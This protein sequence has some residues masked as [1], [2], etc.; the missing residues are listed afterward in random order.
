MDIRLRSFSS[1]RRGASRWLRA[2]AIAAGASAIGL[3][4][5]A[6]DGGGGTG[7]GGAGGA[8]GQGGAGGTG[9]G[10]DAAPTV[11][12][13]DKG[14]I[15]GAVID[16]TRAFLGIPFAAP[17]IDDL[18]W[19]P[20]VPHEPWTDT[21]AATKKG[22]MCPQFNALS[23]KLESGSKEDCLYLN[24]WAPEKPASG[25]LPVLVWIHGGAFVLGSGS[26][27]AYDGKAFSEATGAIV[28]T[29]NYRLGPLGFLALPELK[30]ED[31]GS[32]GTG[33]YGLQDQR[34]ALE[35][36][37]AN[38]GEFGG[39]PGN[40][41]IFGESAGGISVCMHMVSPGSKGL[42]QRAIIESGPCDSADPEAKATA[43]GAT[44]VDK[45]G[46]GGADVLSCLRGKPVEDVMAALPASNDFL[47][48]DVRWFP[49]VDGLDLPDRPGE[50][51]A[52][53]SFEKVPVLLG[54]NADEASLFF[55]LAATTVADDAAFLA[56]AEQL[57]PGNGAEV[58]AHY[59]S[60][61]YGSAQAAAE[62]AVGD[63]AFV[64]ATRRQARAFAAA[65]APTYLY[66]F[67]HDPGAS[68]LGELGAFHSAEI[69]FVLGNPGQLQPG[70]LDGDELALSQAMMGYWSR[71]AD[72]GDPNGEGAFEWPKYDEATDE[73][74]VLE[75]PLSK[76]S[77][78][79]KEQCDF[80]DGVTLPL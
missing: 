8:G 56:L 23:G 42:F 49:V 37:K 40:V 80:W 6:C 16:S 67:T 44:F 20:P 15:E 12:T 27:A 48:G 35:W 58:V 45:L 51:L 71:L 24:V 34:L 11:I 36:V 5:A 3:V 52:A 75:V 7:G 72:K 13:T 59:P 50:L 4:S 31:P 66:H 61:E 26:D 55:A 46:C 54:S 76:Q 28:V 68:L 65:Q 57:V 77:G 74:I 22:P 18:R 29:I 14:V 43:Q 19:K 32:P 33:N 41:T 63:A 73:N 17:P 30:G 60:S 38:I 64:C 9:G 69:K 62:A 53:G 25:A 70:A 47:G 10:S 78:L 21:L 1:G 39:D 79:K 2:A